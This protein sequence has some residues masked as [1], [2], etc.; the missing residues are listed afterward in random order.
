MC[1]LVVGHACASE[2]GGSG[3]N[4]HLHPPKRD[5]SACTRTCRP[6]APLLFPYWRVP[7]RAPSFF[8]GQP[9]WDRLASAPRHSNITR[10]V[11]DDERCKYEFLLRVVDASGVP[12]ELELC[13]VSNVGVTTHVHLKFSAS[14]RTIRCVFDPSSGHATVK[15]HRPPPYTC[16]YAQMTTRQQCWRVSSCMLLSQS[17]LLVVSVSV[18]FQ[19]PTL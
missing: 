13:E 15:Y 1:R 19:H 7:I 2:A 14:I 10:P 12:E 11:V 8:S 18:P 9:E 17:S 6:W 3:D 16:A 5:H 4:A